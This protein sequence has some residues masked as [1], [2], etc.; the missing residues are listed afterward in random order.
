MNRPAP[1]TIPIT[2]GVLAADY[3]GLARVAEA[4]GFDTI[5][6]FLENLLRRLA[7]AGPGIDEVELLVRAGLNDA[8]IA[9]ELNLMLGTV[10]VRRRRLG[11]PPNR[12]YRKAAP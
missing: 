10:R 8:Q 9:T 1:H 6:E 2:V 12:R 4:R 11:L 5:A 3:P 7:L